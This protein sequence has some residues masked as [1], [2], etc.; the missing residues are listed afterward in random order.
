MY[1][2]YFGVIHLLNSSIRV[3][4]LEKFVKHPILEDYEQWRLLV[5]PND[6]L[7]TFPGQV[8]DEENFDE[9]VKLLQFYDPDPNTQVITADYH[10]IGGEWRCFMQGKKCITASK[11]ME[12][13]EPVLE[14]GCPEDVKV[15]AEAAVQR[16]EAPH[17]IY[18]LDM[19]ESRNYKNPEFLP[20]EVN[21]F[22]TAAIYACDAD[23]IVET[24]MRSM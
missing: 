3:T 1:T 12:C 2:S 22:F 17:S 9:K 6:A 19:A 14:E 23:K 18:M 24:V 10:A 20:I 21:P 5:R 4:T 16:W 13:G 11:Y 7:K 15:A 8:I